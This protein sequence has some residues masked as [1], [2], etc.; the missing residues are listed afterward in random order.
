M[1]NKAEKKVRKEFAKQVI[2]AAWDTIK[3][4]EDVRSRLLQ[5]ANECDMPEVFECLLNELDLQ[6]VLRSARE[7]IRK[8][9]RAHARRS[10]TSPARGEAT[11]D[12]ANLPPSPP[13]T[14]DAEGQTDSGLS[15]SGT[16][17]QAEKPIYDDAE[18]RI[19]FISFPD[20]VLTLCQIGTRCYDLNIQQRRLKMGSAQWLL[21][22]P[23]A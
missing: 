3:D 11:L 15:T 22:C 13:S 17:A 19:T 23:R 7:E 14:S 5:H 12:Q 21:H 9:S 8:R 18:V 4:K 1:V 2:I 20:P 10:K 16:A 6:D